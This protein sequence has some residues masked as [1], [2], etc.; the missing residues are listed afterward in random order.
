GSFTRGLFSYGLMEL[1]GRNSTCMGDRPPRICPVVHR[2]ASGNLVAPVRTREEFMITPVSG[3]TALRRNEVSKSY[4]GRHAGAAA[5]RFCTAQGMHFFLASHALVGG[6]SRSTEKTF[7][8]SHQL[9]RSGRPGVNHPKPTV[10][11]FPATKT[12]VVERACIF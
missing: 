4:T 1:R 6:D 9:A 5:R 10:P 8:A 11:A 12:P 7:S 2:S 3:E